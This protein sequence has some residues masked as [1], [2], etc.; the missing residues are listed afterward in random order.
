MSELDA[1]MDKI[2]VCGGTVNS[3]NPDCERCSFVQEIRR[4]NRLLSASRSEVGRLLDELTAVKE[5]R[6]SGQLRS[7]GGIDDD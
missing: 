5:H 4:L 7:W 6:S 3:P 2:C 1:A